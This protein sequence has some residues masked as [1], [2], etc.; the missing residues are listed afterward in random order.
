M[1]NSNSPSNSLFTLALLALTCGCGNIPAHTHSAPKTII[2]D[3]TEYLACEGY[4]TVYN[5][6]R[7]IVSSS[8]G[9]SYE[10]VFTDNYGKSID[11]KDVTSFVVKE[12]PQDASYAMASVATSDNLSTTYSN[13]QPMLPGAIVFFGK[14]GESGRAKWLGR[15]QWRPVPC[16]GPFD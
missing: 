4:V 6:S 11:L 13:G 1:T 10:I 15:G 16:K 14:D 2:A 7:D 12:A 9:H 8:S 3:G 5:P